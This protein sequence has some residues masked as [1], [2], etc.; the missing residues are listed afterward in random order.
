MRELFRRLQYLLHHRRFDDELA[1]DMEFHREMAAREGRRTLPNPLF[2]RESPRRLGL[3]LD[4]PPCSGP[5]LRWQ[6]C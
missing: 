1:R 3:D 6:P 5:A 2:A 4:R